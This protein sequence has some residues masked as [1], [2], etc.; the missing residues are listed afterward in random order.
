MKRVVT[1]VSGSISFSIARVD[2][3]SRAHVDPAISAGFG[4]PKNTGFRV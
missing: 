1:P 2:S 4:E 3:S